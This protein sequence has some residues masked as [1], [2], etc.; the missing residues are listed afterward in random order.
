MNADVAAAWTHYIGFMVLFAALVAEHLLTKK[1]M[2]A[3]EI[4]RVTIID[5]IYGCAAIVVLVTGLLKVFRYGKGAEYYLGAWPFHAK[6]GIFI[7]VALL[8]LYPTIV[9]L[10]MRRKSVDLAVGERL[11]VPPGIKHAIRLELIGILLI[12]L[13]AAL[14]ARGSGQFE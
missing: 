4:R 7:F 5:A 2:T 13:F 12:P 3:L 11:T 6:F 9:F 1:P 14:L 8:S 10:K